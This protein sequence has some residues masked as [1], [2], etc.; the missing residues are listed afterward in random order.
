MICT[1]D[2]RR[3]GGE[4]EIELEFLLRTPGEREPALPL[5]YGLW[6]DTGRSALLLAAKDIL[7]SGGVPFV[8]LPAFCCESVGRTFQQAGFTPRYYSSFELHGERGAEPA[9]ARGETVLI[10]HY[11]GH[12]NRLRVT[13][14]ERWRRD[15]VFV[16]EDAV[17]AGLSGGVGRIGHYAVTSFRKFLP[18]PDGALLGSY[19]PLDVELASPD[20][21]FVTA[22]LLGKLLRGVRAPA[23]S[24]LPLLEEE[25]LR[26][27]AGPIVPR[28]ASWLGRQLLLRSDLAAIAVRRR[29]NHQTLH[30]ILTDRLAPGL[31]PL[32]ATLADDE[33]PLGLPVRVR[34]GGRDELRRQLAAHAVFCAVH[35]PLPHVPED[36]ACAADHRLA[37]EILTLP[38]DQRMGAPHIERLVSLLEGFV[39]EAK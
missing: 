37:S 4:L 34:A 36:P 11:F 16:V 22:R 28:A 15:G 3:I 25:E 23:A 2:T 21:R 13:A 8:W 1:A 39:T 27:D 38:I 31:T 32:L 10:V 24:F 7:R 12:Q 19:R 18:Q 17:Q 35:W 6:T 29:D 14:A 5:P 20:E 26:Y 9:P 30:R 33:V